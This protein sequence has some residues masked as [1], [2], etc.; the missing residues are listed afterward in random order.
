VKLKVRLEAATGHPF[1]T[2]LSSLSGTA[3]MFELKVMRQINCR[4]KQAFANAKLISQPTYAFGPAPK[5]CS[6]I[7]KGVPLVCIWQPRA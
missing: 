1:L 5:R 7:A 2:P 6:P 4:A 3:E